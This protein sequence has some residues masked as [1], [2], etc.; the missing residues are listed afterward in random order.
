MGVNYY[1]CTITVL[2]VT[3]YLCTKY[4]VSTFTHS[5]YML[6]VPKFNKWS[7]YIDERPQRRVGGF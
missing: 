6:G 5:K 3:I 2:L 4:E 1:V 7:Q